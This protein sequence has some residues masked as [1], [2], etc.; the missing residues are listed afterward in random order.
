MIFTLDFQVIKQCDDNSKRN[1]LMLQLAKNCFASI[2]EH[3]WTE[4]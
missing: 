1:K 2:H 4:F 3:A